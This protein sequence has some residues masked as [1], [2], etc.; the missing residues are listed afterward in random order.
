MASKGKRDTWFVEKNPT[1]YGGYLIIHEENG[2]PLGEGDSSQTVLFLTEGKVEKRSKISKNV[3]TMEMLTGEL[4]FI[5]SPTVKNEYIGCDV[6]GKIYTTKKFGGWEVWRFV[7]AGE[8]FVKI[9]SWT[10]DTKYFCSDRTGQVYT[11][12][13]KHP[14]LPGGKEKW[15][16]LKGPSDFH[17]VTIQA[18]STGRYLQLKEGKLQTT[19]NLEG[20]SCVWHLSSANRNRYFLHSAYLHKRVITNK[21]E[22]R[23]KKVISKDLPWTVQYISDDT[24]AFYAEYHDRYLSSDDAGNVS[25]SPHLQ[26]YEKWR[27]QESDDGSFYIISKKHDR[28]LKCDKNGEIHAVTKLNDLNTPSC[29]WYL[30]TD[31]PSA[32]SGKKILSRSIAGVAGVAAGIAVMTP[33]AV[34][35]AGCVSVAGIHMFCVPAWTMG[36]E[37]IFMASGAAAAIGAGAVVSGSVYKAT[38]AFRNGKDCPGQINLDSD[39]MMDEPMRNR[40]FCAWEM[41]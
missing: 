7:E 38:G 19:D 6:F 1:A 37:A 25:V 9:S 5:F 12:D 24:F 31:M 26:D 27:I 10:H 35:S 11:I 20:L 4:C 13:T 40:P 21:I 17:G 23:I 15:K 8:G 3:W 34:A 30:E 33:I 29:K 18:P 32:L 2:E 14:A 39:N 22:P 16:V 28:F 36:T 41:W